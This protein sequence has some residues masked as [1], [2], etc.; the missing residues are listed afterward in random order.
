MCIEPR[1]VMQ[2]PAPVRRSTSEV[3]ASGACWPGNVCWWRLGQDKHV[4]MCSSVQADWC[5]K[6]KDRRSRLTCDGQRLRCLQAAR[7]RRSDDGDGDG[8]LY[9]CLDR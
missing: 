2:V 4:V 1:H 3:R 7:T 9:A 8:D 6:H 5:Q